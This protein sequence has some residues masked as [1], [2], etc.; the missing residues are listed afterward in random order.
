M[1]EIFFVVD[2]MNGK[3]AKW[4]RIL[5][6]SVKYVPSEEDDSSILASLGEGVLITRDSELARKSIRRGH[7]TL[8]IPQNLEEALAVLSK[9]L[10][11]KLRIDARKTRC[12]FC[13]TP[14]ELVKRS[15]LGSEL[16]REILR[17]HRKFLVCRGC[18]KVFWFGSHYWKMLSTLSK[19][20]GRKTQLA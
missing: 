15:D 5:G 13:D 4:I 14:L 8:E 6:Y 11:I 20:R 1:E 18:G 7:R 2:S 19:V 17:G 9:D 16:P 12:P 10:G 3:L